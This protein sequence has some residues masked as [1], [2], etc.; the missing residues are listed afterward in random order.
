M[1]TTAARR[2]VPFTLVLLGLLLLT[3]IFHQTSVVSIYYYGRGFESTES[4]SKPSVGPRETESELAVLVNVTVNTDNIPAFMKE[5]FRWHGKQLLRIQ[6]DAQNANGE[7]LAFLKNYRFLVL[8]CVGNDRCGGLSDRLKGFP[9]FLWYAATTDRILL[10]RW[11]DNRPAPIE[12]FLQPGSFWN[13]T[14]PNVLSQ[15][16]N[17]MESTTDTTIS[18]DSTEFQRLYFHGVQ[19][20]SVVMDK[21]KDPKLW[22]VEGNHYDGKTAYSQLVNAAIEA[23]EDEIKR[24]SSP[25]S[26]VSFSNLQPRDA[27]FRNFYHDLFHATFRPSSRVSELLGAF[28]YAPKTHTEA[29]A[30]PRSWLPVPLQPN[31]YVVSQ[32]RAAYPGEPYRTNGNK[33]ILRETTIHA[34][35]CAKARVEFSR[36]NSTNGAVS[37]VYVTSDTGE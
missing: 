25:S 35:E 22:M 6:Q 2:L 13:W 26:S 20:E 24:S 21:L 28:F 5:Y 10:I 15:K 31:R 30:V 27:D 7:D 1:G 16:L 32:F 37:A 36:G 8:R 9:L 19:R 23:N 33:T 12:T 17:R 18:M 34:V 14:V 29:D 11:G 4:N 3:V